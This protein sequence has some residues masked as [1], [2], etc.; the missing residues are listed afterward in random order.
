[1]VLI[2]ATVQIICS[3]LVLIL[4]VGRVKKNSG[5]TVATRQIPASDVTEGQALAEVAGEPLHRGPVRRWICQRRN[6]QLVN[7]FPVVTK[8]EYEPAGEGGCPTVYV[9][10]SDMP[11]WTW[12]LRPDEMVSV[13]SED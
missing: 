13:V 12:C 4:L 2:L 6:R 9:A 8:A 7:G 3:A 10:S 11:G 5:Q 1:M